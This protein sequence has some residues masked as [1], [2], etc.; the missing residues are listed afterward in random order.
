MPLIGHLGV[1]VGA[2]NGAA[3]AAIGISLSTLTWT[4]FW[5]VWQNRR[6]TRPRLRAT[7]AIGF[8]VFPVGPVRA[9]V[10]LSA[11]NTG[12]VPLTV[13]GVKLNVRGSDND[14]VIIRWAWQT[15]E[16]LPIRLEPGAGLWTGMIEEE[17]IRSILRREFEAEGPWDVRGVFGASGGLTFT[18]RGGRRRH[19][20]RGV[21]WPGLRRYRWTR[22]YDPTGPHSGP[23]PA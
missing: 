13:N 8:P 14:L 9:H 19:R 18:S 23:H 3:W 21:S 7:T 17:E 20:Y 2:S 5:S 15:P 1:V 10:T 6:T 22:I 12:P 4:V 11:A 16:P